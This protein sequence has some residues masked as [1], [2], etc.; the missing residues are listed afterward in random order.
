MLP[1]SGSPTPQAAYKAA[2]QGDPT[3]Q[4]PL[5]LSHPT[6]TEDNP[7]SKMLPSDPRCTF[8][9]FLKDYS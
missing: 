9:T 3:T 5:R 8:N 1:G 6:H 4:R 2:C 7:L